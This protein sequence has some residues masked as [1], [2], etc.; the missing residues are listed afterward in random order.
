MDEKIKIAALL[1]SLRTGSFNKIILDT[2]IELCPS[3]ATIEKVE[4]ANVP[5][6]NGDHEGS[7]PPEVLTFKE[8]IRSAD[9]ILIVTPEY[10]Y[11]IPGGLKNALDWG[12]RPLQDNSFDNK[13]VAI[14]SASPGQ[15]GAARAQYHLRQ[16]FVFLNMHPLN[17]PEVIVGNVQEK[18]DNDGKLKDQHTKDKIVEQLNALVDW[19]KKVKS[20]L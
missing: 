13:P 7:P 1:G 8:K 20:I 11:S 18:V 5:L 10:N 14:M 15:V 4:F 19:T 12:S 9:A 6:Y 3:T 16:C 17:S 2:A